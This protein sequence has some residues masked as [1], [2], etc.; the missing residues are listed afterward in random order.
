MTICPEVVQYK[1]LHRYHRETEGVQPARE[2]G[3]HRGEDEGQVP[4]AV[5]VVA[6]GGG[7]VAVLADGLEHG[8]EGG[9]EDALESGHRED[10][11]RV[12]EVVEGQGAVELEGEAEE[13]ERQ[14]RDP[15]SPS[16]PPSRPRGGRR[17]SRGAARRPG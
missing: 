11:E 3:E 10:N 4:D 1:R 8:A 17:R 15:R 7:A 12:G 6:A 5:D 16:S 9:V 2:A 13:V 14:E